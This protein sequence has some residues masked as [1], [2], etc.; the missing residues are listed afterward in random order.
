MFLWRMPLQNYPEEIQNFMIE[1]PLKDTS[2]DMGNI[3]GT[4]SKR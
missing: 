3:G 1:I 4:Q 2:I